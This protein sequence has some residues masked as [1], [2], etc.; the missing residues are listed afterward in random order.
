MF[1]D[2]KEATLKYESNYTDL[3][4]GDIYA[5]NEVLQE[6]INEGAEKIR[7]SFESLH[8]EVYKKYSELNEKFDFNI[9]QVAKVGIIML[10]DR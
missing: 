3:V 4:R 5:N 2:A 10:K 6:L 9:L 7:Q 1:T 8:T